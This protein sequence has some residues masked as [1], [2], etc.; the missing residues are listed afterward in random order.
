MK[1]IKDNEICTFIN[2]NAE[3]VFVK[4]LPSSKKQGI[5]AFVKNENGRATSMI[6][7][8]NYSFN[9]DDEVKKIGILKDFIEEE[10]T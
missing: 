9:Y 3:D 5:S 1:K 10:G 6:T 7:Q 2:L 8:K 4:I